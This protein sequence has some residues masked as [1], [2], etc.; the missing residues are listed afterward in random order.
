MSILGNDTTGKRLKEE[1][2]LLEK[3][4][5]GFLKYYRDTIIPGIEARIA[6][7]NGLLHGN[8]LFL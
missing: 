8:Q 5:T 3:E 4:M 6:A 7:L 1:K 2:T